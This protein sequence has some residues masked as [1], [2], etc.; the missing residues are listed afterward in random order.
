MRYHVRMVPSR[1]FSLIEVV[2]S[3]FVIGVSVVLSANLLH[4]VPLSR[5][6]KNQDIALK[7]A[8]NKLEEIR[9][10]GYENLPASG[11]FS[12]PLLTALVS[13]AGIVE[14]STYNARTEEVEVTVE[15]NQA[16]AT[17]TI[18]LST[19]VTEVGGLK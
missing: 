12:D 14:I 8:V 18:T 3:I 4:A 16:G 17:S 19:L 10:A 6:A 7:V 9:A 15:W 5:Q 2:V 1:G 13:G 11:P